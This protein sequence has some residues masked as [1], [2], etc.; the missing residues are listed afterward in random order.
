MFKKKISNVTFFSQNWFV[1]FSEYMWF[2]QVFF[3]IF[4]NHVDR[5]IFESYFR[6][7]SIEHF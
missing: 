6:I 1:N 7:I 4:E 5:E 3:L 2:F